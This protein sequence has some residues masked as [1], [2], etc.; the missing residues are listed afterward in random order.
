MDEPERNVNSGVNT[1]ELP[2][3]VPVQSEQAFIT[4][5]LDDPDERLAYIRCLRSFSPLNPCDQINI[6][7]C[8]VA[9]GG[10]VGFPDYEVFQQ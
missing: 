6:D 4:F 7:R 1:S 5:N 9:A 8:I 2:V 10:E 3:L